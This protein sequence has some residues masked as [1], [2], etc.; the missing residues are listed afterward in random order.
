MA[1]T[2]PPRYRFLQAVERVVC[3]TGRSG[4]H[5]ELETRADQG[6]QAQDR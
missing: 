6:G 5:L 2:K 3:S 4:H 1:R